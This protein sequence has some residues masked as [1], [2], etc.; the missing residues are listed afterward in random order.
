MLWVKIH[1]RVAP[2][3][4]PIFRER[5]E[6]Q[7]LTHYRREV[8]EDAFAVSPKL[9]DI[10][11]RARQLDPE[12]QKNLNAPKPPLPAKKK[13]I[14]PLPG[15]PGGTRQPGKKREHYRTGDEAEI[16]HIAKQYKWWE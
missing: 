3:F 8:L 15:D 14:L 16:R 13:D 9:A 4:H 11:A 10:L 7:E 12:V 5:P 2:R 6:I 1:G